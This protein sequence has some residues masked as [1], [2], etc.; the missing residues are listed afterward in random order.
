MTTIKVTIDE[1]EYN[2]Y[3]V[4]I[5]NTKYYVSDSK[6]WERICESHILK[7]YKVKKATINNIPCTIQDVDTH[8]DF[9][10]TDDIKNPTKEDV[11]SFVS[12]IIVNFLS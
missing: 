4:N 10:L 5:N 9:T 7:D 12:E 11:K 8:F 6:L 3:G 2:I 1:N